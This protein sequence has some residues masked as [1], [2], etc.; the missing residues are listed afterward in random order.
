MSTSKSY[1]IYNVNEVRCGGRQPV[2]YENLN[3]NKH[4]MTHF[5]NVM[6]L[7]AV[8]K[9]PKDQRERIQANNEI[10]IANRKMAYWTRHPN[11]KY[12]DI[13]QEIKTLKRQWTT[14]R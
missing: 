9:A 2:K 8:L 11:F 1:I 12:A 14:G 6:F 10:Q 4:Y 5:G 13:E 3:A 7:E